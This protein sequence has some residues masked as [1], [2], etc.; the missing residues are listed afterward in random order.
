MK[1]PTK[2]PAG[3]T[4]GL[5]LNWLGKSDRTATS[6]APGKPERAGATGNDHYRPL[7]HNSAGDY[8]DRIRTAVAVGGAMEARAATAFGACAADTCN[9]ASDQ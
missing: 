8:H 6:I 3:L 5:F 1:S 4:A 2:N 9:R 7:D